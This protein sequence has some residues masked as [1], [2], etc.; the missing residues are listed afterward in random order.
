[1]IGR[2]EKCMPAL[3]LL[4]VIMLG[5]QRACSARR[6]ARSWVLD[7]ARDKSLKAEKGEMFSSLSKMLKVGSSAKSAKEASANKERNC[8]T[9]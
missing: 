2:V 4:Y 1:M 9:R 3:T 8:S 6:C 7:E 5:R